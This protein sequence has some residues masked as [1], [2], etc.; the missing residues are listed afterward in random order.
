MRGLIK[1]AALLSSV[2]SSGL[3]IPS[4]QLSGLSWKSVPPVRQCKLPVPQNWEA[5]A[6]SGPAG[7]EAALE[8]AVD[9]VEPNGQN[10]VGLK[11][12]GSDICLSD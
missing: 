8:H 6:K 5:I 12:S 10:R 9:V 3:V 4:N 2:L 7:S 1:V 11:H